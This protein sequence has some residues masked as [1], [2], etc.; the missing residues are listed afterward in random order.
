MPAR[1]SRPTRPLAGIVLVDKP[2]GLTSNR[3]LQKTK[4]LYQASKAGHTGTLDPLATGML[5][6]CFGSATRVSGM[7]LEASKRYEVT[8]AFGL[9]TATGDS[10]GEITEIRDSAPLTLD[11]IEPAVGRMVGRTSQVPPMF[12][13]VKHEGRRLYELARQGMEVPREPR[14]IEIHS[15]R[16]EALEWPELK[17]SVHCSKGTYVR[18]LVTDLA[19]ALGTVAHVTALRRLAVGPFPEARMVALDTLE[20]A[21]LEGLESLDRWL[22]GIDAALTDWPA[23][24]VGQEQSLALRQGREV[25]IPGGKPPGEV[26]IYDDAGSFIGTGMLSGRGG[27][28]PT[29]IFQR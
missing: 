11:A 27:I 8:A 10:M 23:V 7:M 13:A 9:A 29:R 16:I 4:R 18:T 12:S 21:A 28:K 26:R 2:Q 20:E 6:I 5:P 24:S 17:L 1:S 22:L 14:Q 3:V 19:G 15:L 25:E